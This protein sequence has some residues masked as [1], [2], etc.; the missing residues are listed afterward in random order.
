MY[1]EALNKIKVLQATLK[2]TTKAAIPPED[3]QREVN[4]EHSPSLDPQQLLSLQNLNQDPVAS[5]ILH[6]TQAH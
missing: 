6:W 1:L 4:Q 3:L 5:S 2:R